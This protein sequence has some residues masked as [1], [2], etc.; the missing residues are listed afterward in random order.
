MFRVHSAWSSH[1]LSS[2]ACTHLLASQTAIVHE[3]ASSRQSPFVVHAGVE[4]CSNP[5]A[6]GP[7]N[8]PPAVLTAALAVFGMQPKATKLGATVFVTHGPTAHSSLVAQALC[9]G[10]LTQ[11][12]PSADAPPVRDTT[13]PK[14]G[15]GAVTQVPASLFSQS[16]SVVQARYC[17]VEQ[18]PLSGVEACN[19][20][21]VD[22]SCVVLQHSSAFT[23]PQIRSAQPFG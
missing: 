15:S 8:P 21:A 3:N 13:L 16:L 12:P 17:L 20:Q 7:G 19:G 22:P 18:F 6:T 5:N 14:H 1:R 23:L 2:L 9:P 11:W 10:S 4:A